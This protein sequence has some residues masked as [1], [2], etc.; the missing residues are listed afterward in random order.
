MS[1]NGNDFTIKPS[2]TSVENIRK[3]VSLTKPT[4]P[5]PSGG[6]GHGWECTWEVSFA[7][8]EGLHAHGHAR[9][10]CSLGVRL[11][12]ELLARPPALGASEPAEL[13]RGRRRHCPPPRVSAAS[14]R[15]SCLASATLA[16]C[17]FLCT[18]SIA[19]ILCVCMYV[20]TV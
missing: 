2:S 10:A 6:I 20:S 11:A 18:V 13:R 14:H 7:R 12:R 4:T 15:L 16:K 3:V 5:Q 1:A 17:A 8:A 9:E 19:I